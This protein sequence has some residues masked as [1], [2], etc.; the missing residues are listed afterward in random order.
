MGGL[1]G[2]AF[3]TLAASGLLGIWVVGFPLW[4][5]LV[6]PERA[7]RPLR[8]RLR[9]AVL[10]VLAAPGRM[11]TLGLLL[12]IVLLISTV[13]FAALLTISVSYV[14]AGRRALRPAAGRSPRDLARRTRGRP[15][16]RVT[17]SA[18]TVRSGEPIIRSVTFPVQVGPTA[19]TINRDDR[20]VVCQPDG[21]ILGGVDDGFFTRDTR[22]ISGYELRINGRRPVLLNSAPIQF[23]SA[24][25]EFTNDALLDDVGRVE[26][27]ALSIRLDRTVS[28][29][30]HEDLDIVNYGRRPVRL[31]IEIEIESD[32]ADIF[33]VRGDAL[34]RRGQ[35]NSRWFRSRR[36]LRS[37]Y[38]NRDFRRELIVAVDRS[39]SPPQYANGRLVFVARI[40]PKA[41]W[42]TC[43]KWLPVTSSDARRRPTDPRLQ[44]RRSSARRQQPAP[45]RGDDR[46]AE[47]HRPAGV[48]PGGPRHG[49]APPR[50]SDVRAGRLHPGRRRPLVRDALRARHA[51][52]LDA[53][54]LRLS[55]VRLRGAAPPRGDAGDRRRP[56]T[57]HGAGQ[58]PA[59]DPPRRA[60]PARDPAVHAVLRHPRRDEPLSHRPVVPLPVARRR[61]RPAALPAERGGGDALDRPPRRPRPGR[62][63]GVQ[64]PLVARL[65]Q[66]GLEGRRRCDPGGRRDAGAAADR[67]VR[68]P[69]LRLRREAADGRHLRHPRPAD[70]RP[71]APPAGPGALRSVQRAVL[72][73]GGGDLLPR[74]QREEGADP[75]G[76][77]ERRPSAP[78]GDRPDGAGRPRG[79]APPGRRH[80]VGLGHPDTLVGARGVQPVQLPHGD[81]SGPTTTR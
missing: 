65:L 20:F 19:I 14:R 54:D 77:V 37:E 59:R 71:A 5:L 35:L 76:R 50:G 32:F 57:G 56:G 42:H 80:V 2:W 13:A 47:R 52:R 21:R 67:P 24:R 23:F 41:V 3:A 12:L 10:L 27:H 44:R 28:G 74:P 78:V 1:G 15:R 17:P 68:A 75:D 55:G 31:T 64:D 79:E 81:R 25:F 9:L 11:V 29:G 73:G 26:R 16:E 66:P 6:D 45:A 58:D 40:A 48:G 51:D 22:F 39:D 33:D 38:V 7:D 46:D 61:R 60:G 70:R 69:G 72:V 63:P 18:G 53:G 43:L 4:I 34:V 49:G 36:E 30:V 62:V 8:D